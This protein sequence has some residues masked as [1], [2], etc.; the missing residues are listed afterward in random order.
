M[1]QRGVA[2]RL[3]VAA[4]S[5]IYDSKSRLVYEDLLRSHFVV[6]WNA[7]DAISFVQ[8]IF[9]AH[10]TTADQV[11]ISVQICYLGTVS[12]QAQYGRYHVIFSLWVH[13]ASY[14]RNGAC[15]VLYRTHG[16]RI[17]TT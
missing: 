3:R 15:C 6:S 8:L 7:A 11:V 12:T 2:A 13:V 10:A 14:R 4:A 17:L 5:S 1:S 9:E 16:L